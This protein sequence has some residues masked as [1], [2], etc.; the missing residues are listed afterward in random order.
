MWHY[1]F[2]N[3]EI[4]CYILL[5]RIRSGL[6]WEVGSG[7]GPRPDRIRNT[8]CSNLF[9]EVSIWI[10]AHFKVLACTPC[11]KKDWVHAGSQQGLLI[12]HTPILA[13]AFYAHFLT[14][15]QYFSFFV[16]IFLNISAYF[17]F[18]LICGKIW[19]WGGIPFDASRE[20]GGEGKRNNRIM[21]KRVMIKVQ[22]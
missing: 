7:S 8:A 6:S 15:C 18:W 10:F 5:G 22:C 11:V 21:K 20:G 14:T 17:P 13:Q 9:H 19:R 2:K 3:N 1:K 4:D 16:S 12:L